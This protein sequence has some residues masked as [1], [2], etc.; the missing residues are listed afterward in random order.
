MD[1]DEL[2][3]YLGSRVSILLIEN[4]IDYE[5]IENPVKSFQ[6]EKVNFLLSPEHKRIWNVNF[7]K[8][9]FVDN[10]WR[11]QFFGGETQTEYLNV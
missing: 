10:V 9:T 8:H 6:V 2:L 3:D 11:F 5:D 4:Y 1:D 7:Q